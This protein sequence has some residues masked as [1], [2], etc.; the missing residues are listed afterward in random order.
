MLA[1]IVIQLVVMVF[2]V[3]YTALWVFRAKEKVRLAG[4][5]FQCMLAGMLAASIG[6]IIR[7]VSL[8]TL[9]LSHMKGRTQTDIAGRAVVLPYSGTRRRVFGVDRHSADLDAVRRRSRRVLVFRPQVSNLNRGADLM[10]HRA[11]TSL[12]NSP[13]F[14]YRSIIHPHWFLVYSP[15]I[16]AEQRWFFSEKPR[17]APAAAAADSPSG[18]DEGMELAR[19]S[20]SQETAVAM[21]D[22]TRALNHDAR[23]DATNAMKQV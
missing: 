9:G 2:Y 13:P 1:G 15:E 16:V 3:G 22:E 4:S 6:I 11:L 12:G 14:F 5:R 17:E 18:A 19:R 21:V 20:D 8:P 23:F 7:G 10:V